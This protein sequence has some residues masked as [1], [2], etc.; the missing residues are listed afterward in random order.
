M[1]QTTRNEPQMRNGSGLYDLTVLARHL[2]FYQGLPLRPR[3]STSG[4][5]QIAADLI[6]SSNSSA[7]GQKQTSGKRGEAL[8]VGTPMDPEIKAFCDSL[9]DAVTKG[10]VS[11]FLQSAIQ[12]HA[13]ATPS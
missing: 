8:L 5:P 3:G 12:E 13:K 1:V 7:S 11:D 10:T 6:A 2:D 9:A 4:V